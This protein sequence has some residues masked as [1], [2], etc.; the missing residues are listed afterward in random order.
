M[1]N[2]VVGKFRHRLQGL[3]RTLPSTNPTMATQHPSLLF[4]QLN[5][6][7]FE[8]ARAYVEQFDDLPAFKEILQRF[9]LQETHGEAS[10]EQLEPWI[11]WVSAQTGKTF[12]EHGV[13][14]LGDI[15][16][17]QPVLPQ[18][19]EALEQ[20]GLKVGAISPMNAA[21]RL[22]SPAYFIPDPWTDTPSDESPFAG[23]LTAMLRQTVNEN[24]VQ[25]ISTRSVL[26]LI[27]AVLRT[28][29]FVRTP[30]L[31][32]LIARS[33]GRPWLKA[34]VLDAL[35][36]LL[37]LHFL[38]TK[39]PDVSFAFLNAG[40]HIQHHYFFNTAT[41]KDLPH[42]PTWYVR[43]DADPIH[44][45][46]RIYDGLLADYLRMCRAGAR[47]IIATGLTQVPYNHVKFYYRLK[48]HAAFLKVLGL[49]F[50]R[51]QPRMTRDFEIEFSDNADRD[52][53][54]AALTAL[55]VERDGLPAF[56]D[57]EVRE[58]SVFVSLVYPHEI[59]AEDVL[60]GQD[61][62]RPL[63]IHDLV[64]FVAIKNGMHSPKGFAY[65]SP[66]ITARME[67]QAVHV[68]KLFDLTLDSVS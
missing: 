47:C 45:M 57:V 64:A 13:F 63:A 56:G 12:A 28:F 4:I 2:E 29:D 16:R 49:R 31:L 10:Y 68:A 38:K 36:H 67:A 18:I 48:D 7:N 35:I 33:R 26:T 8:L 14:R 17:H 41:R 15:V 40:A 54:V 34:V 24:A 1:G 30:K 32:V 52:A 20:R 51:V 62:H 66:N 59:Q 53:A 11:Q 39:R 21:N 37:H 65:F 46:L 3:F 27:E 44:D 58:C 60:V 25:R 19:F 42:N 23:R 55:R 50:A 9:K 61:G 43:A 6:I 5:E 22:C